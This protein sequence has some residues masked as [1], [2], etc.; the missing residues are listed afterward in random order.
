MGMQAELGLTAA[1]A[2]EPL[3]LHFGTGGAAAS[4]GGGALGAFR[5]SSADLSGK[6]LVAALRSV[7]RLQESLAATLPGLVAT[8]GSAGNADV[9]EAALKR[10][11]PLLHMGMGPEEAQ[12]EM[13]LAE[14][15]QVTG[16]D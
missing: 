15:L 8:H 1:V 16:G 4:P 7:R 14:E 12:L 11:Q 9:L 6:H 10:L 5:A 13:E 3:T 2:A